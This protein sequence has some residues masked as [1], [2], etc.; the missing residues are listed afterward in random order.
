MCPRHPFESRLATAWPPSEWLEVTVL[1]AVSGGPDSVA[2]LRALAALKTGGRG[3]LGVAHFNHRLR[4]A[5]AE[6][7][8]AFI[9]ALSDRL[10]LG[11][12]V[13]RASP[14]QIAAEA[15]D[16]LEASARK[17][18]YQFLRETAD[19]LGARYVA[20]GHTADDQVETILHRVVRGTGIAGLAG[21][22][23]ARPLSGATTLIRPVLAFRRE[24]VL[25]YLD[26]LRQPFRTDASNRDT[27]L[28]RN[29]IRHEL[30]PL[31]AEKFNPEIDRAL[32]RLGQLAGQ[33]Q[34]VLDDWIDELAQRH[35]SRGP[36]GSV[37]VETAPLTARPVHVV[38]ELLI[39][40]W[41]GQG[42]PLQ[43]MGFD[44]WN[45]LAAMALGRG[46]T[47]K[48][49]PGPIQAQREAGQLHLRRP[50]KR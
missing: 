42:W 39:A 37:R 22:A 2:L 4:G 46:P 21:M 24:E 36:D 18:R 25:A 19:R 50:G 34:A 9:V 32:L 41:R 38:R 28:T 7:D 48:T 15:A 43:A 11:C 49:F 30:L 8:E 40:A 16:G 14:G 13:G 33:T 31:L 17:A 23:R 29:R 27:R 12:E 26:D 1:V 47:K 3:R 44:Q 20:T 35:I 10:G 5:D 45:E 6:A